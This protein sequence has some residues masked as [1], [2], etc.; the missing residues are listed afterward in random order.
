MYALY[1]DTNSRVIRFM[2]FLNSS[3]VF[4]TSSFLLRL[5]SLRKLEDWMETG[6]NFIADQYPRSLRA[7][8]YHGNEVKVAAH[9]MRQF[10]HK[11]NY[12]FI[13]TQ[14]I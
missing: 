8:I 4:R 11:F 6:C 2:V 5:P 3:F 7:V 13:P 14:H 1:E 10:Q 12:L 9:W